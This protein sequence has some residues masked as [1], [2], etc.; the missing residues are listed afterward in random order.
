MATL[1]NIQD[2]ATVAFMTAFGALVCC[3]MLAYQIRR[4]E[5]TVENLSARLSTCINVVG[6]L[7]RYVPMPN[8]YEI[9]E[10]KDG[11]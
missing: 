4:L 7:Q 10:P 2:V 8:R 9:V 5:R 1:E 11:Q 6:I 3:A